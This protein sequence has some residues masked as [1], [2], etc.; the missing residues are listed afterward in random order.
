[1]RWQGFAP[2]SGKVLIIKYKWSGYGFSGGGVE[3]GESN[4][5]A[6]VRELREEIGCKVV[7]VGAFL[8]SVTERT[9]SDTFPNKY[10]EQVNLCYKCEVDEKSTLL[11]CPTL[12]EI[13]R[14]YESIWVD[15]HEALRENE[16]IPQRKRDV[17]VLELLLG[18]AV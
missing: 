6:V 7:N 3:T 9:L 4:E 13:D 15:L 8:I 2:D 18:G 1:L 16:P 14:E 10:F 5:E 17:A 12:E 11:P